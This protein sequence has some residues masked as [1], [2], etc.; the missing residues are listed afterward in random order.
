M[1][2]AQKFASKTASK[3]TLNPSLFQPLFIPLSPLSKP[4]AFETPTPLSDAQ[5]DLRAA[6][7]ARL[8][9]TPEPSFELILTP[10]KPG[11]SAGPLTWST[12]PGSTLQLRYSPGVTQMA[13][14][15]CPP[16][17]VFYPD[18]QTHVGILHYCREDNGHFC[19]VEDTA[20]P[21]TQPGIGKLYYRM[22]VIAEN[23]MLNAETALVF[24]PYNV[25]L[26]G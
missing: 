20:L 7:S 9:K 4:L 25:L 13:E 18:P 3:T 17:N 24:T 16:M 10:T 12:L 2:G 11:N 26:V 21:G 1:A 23:G 15:P 6:T 5:A 19:A 22:R 14:Y 8:R